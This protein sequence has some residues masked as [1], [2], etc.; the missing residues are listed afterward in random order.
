MNFKQGLGVASK[1]WALISALLLI[2]DIVFDA[3]QCVTYYDFANVESDDQ[4]NPMPIHIS[5]W[6]FIC[7]M[8]TWILPP[9]L[10]FVTMFVFYLFDD[11]YGQSY[12]GLLKLGLIKDMHDRIEH[13]QNYAEKFS[14]GDTISNSFIRPPWNSKDRVNAGY[15]EWSLCKICLHGVCWFLGIDRHVKA[16]KVFC[17]YFLHELGITLGCFMTIYTIFIASLWNALAE[18]CL[19]PENLEQLESEKNRARVN[20]AHSYQEIFSHIGEAIPQLSIAI[21][22]YYNN[23]DYVNETDFGF[24]ILGFTMTQTLI[25]MILSII[26]IIKGIYTGLKA[27]C[28]LKVWKS[29][30]RVRNDNADVEMNVISNQD[31]AIPKEVINDINLDEQSTHDEVPDQVEKSVDEIKSQIQPES[32]EEPKTVLNLKVANAN[33]QEH[34]RYLQVLVEHYRNQGITLNLYKEETDGSINTIIQS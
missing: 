21:V 8:I 31:A 34:M 15:M 29:D 23:F 24:V 18:L 3:L 22:Y 4:T 14:F 20:L 17:K 9:M 2:A 1:L 12:Y 10:L 25:S 16:F 7:S 19:S 26:S 6:Y 27:C 33:P 32:N 13:T 30:V 11:N 28:G 5:Q